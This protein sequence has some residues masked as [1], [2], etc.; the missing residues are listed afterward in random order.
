M[1]GSQ[2]L[3]GGAAVGG[4]CH[5]VDDGERVREGSVGR[6]RSENTVEVVSL[7]LSRAGCHSRLIQLGS[8]SQS[9]HSGK[10]VVLIA[11]RGSLRV[12]LGKVPRAH[13]PVRAPLLLRHI[14]GGEPLPLSLG[15]ARQAVK[16]DSGIFHRRVSTYDT[17]TRHSVRSIYCTD[18]HCTPSRAVFTPLS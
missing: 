7:H 14:K 11:E 15:A 2:L 16:G 13:S 3:C 10:L 9:P 18:Y 5:C 4:G 8:L 1:H 12:A 17:V 6:S